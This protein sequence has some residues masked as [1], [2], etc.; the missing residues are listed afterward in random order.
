MNIESEIFMVSGG[1]QAAMSE[2]SD[3]T[4]VWEDGDTIVTRSVPGHEGY[5]Y[6]TWGEDDDVPHRLINLIGSD[7]V[8]AQNKFFNVL[9]CYGSGLRFV[10]ADGAPTQNKDLKLWAQ[11]QFLPAYFL[12]QCT[13]MK[14][15]FFTVCVFILS[16]DGQKINRIQCREGSIDMGKYL[17]GN[18]LCGIK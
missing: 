9:T 13:D 15:F 16:R 10:D 3:T 2:V 6:V 1:V 18:L 8:T 12:N 17:V 5:D 14:Y 4:T 7:E 11:R